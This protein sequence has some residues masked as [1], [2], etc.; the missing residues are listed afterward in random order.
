MI[1]LPNPD[2]SINPAEPPAAQP[3]VN[4]T[5]P[6][7]HATDIHSLINC[8]QDEPL[9]VARAILHAGGRDDP[10]AMIRPRYSRTMSS[11]YLS[12][13]CQHCDA[14]QGALYIGEAVTE[15]VTA[16][17]AF[18]VDALVTLLTGPCP[19]E[20]WQRLVLDP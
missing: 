16:T 4:V 18:T 12:S 8:G 6:D 9:E 2:I 20:T 10:G 1:V 13:G 14:I 11:A 15:T 7:R 5:V 17:G 3:S 19:S